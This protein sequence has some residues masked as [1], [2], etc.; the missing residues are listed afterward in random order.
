MTWGEKK[1]Y[2]DS[3]AKCFPIKRPRDR[4]DALKSKRLS[5]R[6]EEKLY[7]VCKT[8][9]LNTLCIGKSTV[10]GYKTKLC[11][12]NFC[13]FDLTTK[14]GY[15]YLWNEVEGGLNA[16]EY[17][18]ILGKFIIQKFLPRL[19]RQSNIKLILS[20]NQKSSCGLS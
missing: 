1:V 13:L 11:V 12:H 2:V 15:C 8:I 7:R 19:N 20:G 3:L 4:K 5:S 10:R 9:F 18:S 14:A 6:K 17:A 16:E